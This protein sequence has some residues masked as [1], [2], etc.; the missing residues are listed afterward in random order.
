MSLKNITVSDFVWDY[1]YDP[2]NLNYV[3]DI[4]NV[5][6][7]GIGVRGKLKYEGEKISVLGAVVLDPGS[8]EP[9][10]NDKK[11]KFT[12]YTDG[13]TNSDEAVDILK[14]GDAVKAME[15]LYRQAY[16]NTDMYSKRYSVYI[17]EDAK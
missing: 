11:T 13:L 5:K 16:G 17:A 2:D 15:K 10:L 9:K 6:D 8:G 14:G 7:Y 1:E 4:G 3:N 12:A